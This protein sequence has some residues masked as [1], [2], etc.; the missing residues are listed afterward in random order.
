MNIAMNRKL[1]LFALAIAFV[2]CQKDALIEPKTAIVEETS[3]A[4]L[5]TWAAFEWEVDYPGMVSSRIWL[6]TDRDMR[7]SFP[8]PE[9]SNTEKKYAQTIRNLSGCTWYYY[10]YEVYNPGYSYMTEMDSVLTDCSF[11]EISGQFSVSAD[12][13]VKF[14]Q[15]NL[16]YQAS[17]NTWRFAEYQWDFVGSQNPSSDNP[18]P[19]GTVEGSDN[20]RIASNYDGW[21]DL[22]GWGTSGY[23]DEE[24]LC[25]QNYNPWSSSTSQINDSQYNYYGY[26]PSTNTPS[27]NLTEYSANY[28]WGVFNSVANGG[29][30][31]GLWRTLTTDEW[32]YVFEIRQTLSRIRFAKAI[33]NNVRGTILL[34]DDWVKSY[35]ELNS[36]NELAV[37]YSVNI[38]RDSDW[39]ILESHGAVFL[40]AAGFREGSTVN[41][42]GIAGVYWS[43]SHFS[44]MSSFG[45]KFDG[46][47]LD[48]N[49]DYRRQNGLSVR[50]VRDAE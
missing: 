47:S 32:E 3:K 10:R 34:P 1:L 40:P 37:D 11:G 7:D 18:I 12:K 42:P 21:I 20:S 5:S 45:V 22:F 24:D 19:A 15:G 31:T 44:N 36:T 50:L 9:M 17:T 29:G 39:A 46:S 38:I 25:N 6:S 4:V 48:W 33:V 35:Y 13:K 27:P 43:T 41:S 2:G 14:S 26:G 28:D 30:Q 8:S 23:H 49:H 16:Q